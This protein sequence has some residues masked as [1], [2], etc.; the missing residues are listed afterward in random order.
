YKDWLAEQRIKDKAVEAKVADKEAPKN[1]RAQSKAERQARILERRPLVKESEQLE[2]NMATWQQ[3]KSS[4]DE[5][6]ADASLYE[7][8]GKA[9]LQT[10]VKRQAELGQQLGQAEE[11]WLEVHEMLEAIPAIN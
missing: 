10:L 11:R 8:A 3:E 5:R 9:E 2:A 1:D 7:A 4:L 6:M